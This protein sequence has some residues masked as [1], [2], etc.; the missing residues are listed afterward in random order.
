MEF[1][2][3]CTVWDQKAPDP[4]ARCLFSQVADAALLDVRVEGS[5]L[6]HADCVTGSMESLHSAGAQGR[7][8]AADIHVSHPD[9]RQTLYSAEQLAQ[10]DGS[11]HVQLHLAA[12]SGKSSGEP[13]GPSASSVV[14]FTRASSPESQRLVFSD[15]CACAS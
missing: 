4:D 10:S 3:S 15:R 8:H 5:L 11:A 13:Q 14:P 6:V 12:A 7:G 2:Q 1:F 9:G